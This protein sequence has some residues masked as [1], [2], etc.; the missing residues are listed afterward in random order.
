MTGPLGAYDGVEL[1]TVRSWSPTTPHGRVVA[2]LH[3]RLHHE[4]QSTTL[5]GVLTRFCDDLRIAGVRPVTASALFW[6][7]V[8]RAQDVHEVYATTLATG[9]DAP[10]VDLLANNPLYRA[11]RDRG[12]ALTGATRD[13]WEIDR[14]VIDAS[15]RACMMARGLVPLAVAFPDVPI[16]LFDRP[17]VR[18]D[19]RLRALSRIDLIDAR[20]FLDDGPP[21]DI[22]A[23]RRLHDRMADYLQ[24]RGL[25]TLSTAE[26]A[27]AV[28]TLVEGV[29]AAVPGLVIEID[30]DRRD[31]VQDMLKESQRERIELHER[32]L[33]VEVMSLREAGSRAADFLRHHDDLGAHLLAVW[34]RADLL[35]RQ[36][37]D[38][39]ILRERGGHVAALQAA[40]DSD[41]GPVVL[42]AIADDLGEIVALAAGLHDIE[43]LFLTTQASILDAPDAV[44]FSGERT[45]HVLVDQPVLEQLRHTFDQGAAV[46]WARVELGGDRQLALFV[47]EVDALPHV[48]YL[49]LAGEVAADALTR[50]LR[51]QPASR[52]AP[53]GS[54]YTDAGPAI[55]AIIQHV[56]AAWWRLD[57]IGARPG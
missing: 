32:P 39:D 47:F 14:H 23:L 53:D 16:A 21:E 5:W 55:E 17:D 3:E 35:A 13:S 30:D 6:I 54:V 52:A 41:G 45:I 40:A 33:P 43:M 2:S 38:A 8:M 48:L 31:A 7:G 37:G 46:R 4:L 19:D 42:L 44:R 27:A 15:L 57:Q 26:Y 1:W 11:H 49:H 24:A 51:R 18:P 25:P 10:S 50:W 9:M 20:R 36:F 29:R 56:V 28:D 34:V 12:L 22:P